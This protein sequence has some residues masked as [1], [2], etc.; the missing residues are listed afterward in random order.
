MILMKR[1]LA[2]MA[3]GALLVGCTPTNNDGVNTANTTGTT[4]VEG[5]TNTNTTTTPTGVTD[6]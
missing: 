3:T 6:N 1:I 5:T 2:V 4:N